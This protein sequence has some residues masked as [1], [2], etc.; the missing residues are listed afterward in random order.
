M[1]KGKQKAES[2]SSVSFDNIPDRTR[3]QSP[4]D[5]SKIQTPVNRL[6]V[7]NIVKDDNYE[8][9]LM[10]MSVPEPQPPRFVISLRR[11]NDK[12]ASLYQI[13]RDECFYWG[14]V[15]RYDTYVLF[16][17]PRFSSWRG[18]GLLKARHILNFCRT[19][20]DVPMQPNNEW[21]LNLLYKLEKYSFITKGKTV[22]WLRACGQYDHYKALW[23]QMN[24]VPQRR[25][26]P[27][28]WDSYFPTVLRMHFS[29]LASA[30]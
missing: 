6:R 13:T 1:S 4:V 24:A 11:P 10:V 22:E 16:S 20:M 25:Y 28:K 12:G 23:E 19:L 14:L 9:W 27:G 3:S 15:L 18:M 5:R 29:L 2:S 7:K 21:I 26:L 17:D 8:I 30:G